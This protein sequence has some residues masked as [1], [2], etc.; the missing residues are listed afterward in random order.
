MMRAPYPSTARRLKPLAL[1]GITTQAAM[2]RRWAA[3]ARAAPWLPEEWVATPFES[4]A[5][6]RLCTALVAP[7]SLKAPISCRFSH[8]KK[9]SAPNSA[10]RRGQR[11]TGVRR[12]WGA[13]R[14]AAARMASIFRISCIGCSGG[15][16]TELR[17]QQPFAVEFELR[18]GITDVIQGEV[19]GGLGEGARRR[20]PALRQ[21]LERAHVQ[22]AVVEEAFQ[23]RHV[24]RQET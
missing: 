3:S 7:R 9:I 16:R 15:R 5:S 21:L 23:L 18:H 24:P 10:S 22:V 14:A 13:M 20:R 6:G 19:G 12:T 17:P 4:A 1:S 11:I 2:P 8:L